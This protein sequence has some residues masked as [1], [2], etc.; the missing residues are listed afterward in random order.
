MQGRWNQ[1]KW[2]AAL[3]LNRVSLWLVF[4]P[5]ILMRL[6]C[7]QMICVLSCLVPMALAAVAFLIFIILPA[8]ARANNNRQTK[9]GHDVHTNL[10]GISSAAFLFLV[11]LFFGGLQLFLLLKFT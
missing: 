9:R 10:E 5:T 3:Y 4:L 7:L 2:K 6:D 11:I 8:G 1:T